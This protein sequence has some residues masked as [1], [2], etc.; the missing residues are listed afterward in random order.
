[1]LISNEIASMVSGISENDTVPVYLS[2][3]PFF[4][5]QKE[6]AL[7]FKCRSYKTYLNYSKT[8]FDV[9]L[10]SS[11]DWK[12]LYVNFIHRTM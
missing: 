8:P 5:K 9:L 10:R 2:N 11:I 6:N 1:M 7:S 12:K 4:T 3:E